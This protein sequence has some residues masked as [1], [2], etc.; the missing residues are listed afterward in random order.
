MLSDARITAHYL[1]RAVRCF[2]TP[3]GRRNLAHTLRRIRAT[4]GAR[5]ARIVLAQLSAENLRQAN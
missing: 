5:A 4:N 1:R 3:A 2:S